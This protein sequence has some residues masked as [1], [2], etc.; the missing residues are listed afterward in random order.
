MKQLFVFA[1]LLLPLLSPA[2]EVK[3]RHEVGVEFTNKDAYGLTYRFG[4]EQA[5]WRVRATTCKGQENHYNGTVL[6]YSYSY[7]E[8]KCGFGREYRTSIANHLAIRC[9]LDVT[10]STWD[11]GYI[12]NYFFYEPTSKIHVRS[13]GYEPGLNLI[14][15][16]SYQVNRLVLGMEILPSIAYMW[17]Y[18]N[19][20]QNDI[21]QPS[22]GY[23]KLTYGLN[24]STVLISAVYQF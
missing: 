16:M 23:H 2:Q 10:F 8:L 11:Q 12:T 13:H 17:N 21:S 22:E 7:D 5:L 24:T 6:N 3:K 15:G 20:H 9:G 19:S 1:L 14:A 18:F 4:N